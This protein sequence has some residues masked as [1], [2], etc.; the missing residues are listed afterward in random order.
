MSNRARRPS[1]SARDSL[2]GIKDE[3]T[4]DFAQH[5]ATARAQFLRC[6]AS[7]PVDDI[8]AS[9][10]ER[11]DMV[12]PGALL[13]ATGWAGEDDMPAHLVL[14]VTEGVVQA[15]RRSSAW[16][17]SGGLDA[18]VMAALGSVVSRD[19]YRCGGA[20]QCPRSCP[21]LRACMHTP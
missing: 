7:A 11:W 2:M 17:L 6:S 3:G 8:A 5:R 15:A 19:N 16:I 13:R 10:Q 12:P 4:I 21:V 1:A 9:L 14:P 20:S 18:G